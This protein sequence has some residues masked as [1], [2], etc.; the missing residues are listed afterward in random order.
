MYLIPPKRICLSGGGIRAVAF[1]GALEVLYQKSLLVAVKE[2]VGI[3]AGAFICFGL[4]V[5]YTFAEMKQVAFEFDFSHIRSFEAD[6]AIDFL[7]TY[8]FD[9]GENLIKLLESLLK[10][11]HLPA[12]LT[13]QQL[14]EH[15]PGA[16][17][18]RCFATDLTCCTPREF[19][20]KKTPTVRI[21][22]ALRASMSLPLY[23]TPVPDPETGHLLSDGA[24][25]DTYPM[26]FLRDEE[27]HESLGFVFSNDHV[28]N[29]EI[30]EPFDF[31]QQMLA[32]I[33]LPRARKILEE[34]SENTVVLPNGEFPSWNF[35]ASKEDRIRLASSAAEATTKFLKG[36]KPRAPPRR[37]SVA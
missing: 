25:L 37:Y 23:F 20:Y 31:L 13:F 2:Y 27:R 24:L 30:N 18:L 4:C 10:Q 14:H 33:Y 7:E 5:G 35:E 1:L 29:C 11:K 21:V 32:C 17:A 28:E 34:C 15:T 19:S 22:D 6:S 9:S 3:S 26:A 36:W 16:P 8:G 12:S